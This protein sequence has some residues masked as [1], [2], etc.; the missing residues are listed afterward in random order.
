MPGPSIEESVQNSD[1]IFI[2]KCIAGE[3]IE[4]GDINSP[5]EYKYKVVWTFEVQKQI[6]GQ[7]KSVKIQVETGIGSGDCGFPFVFGFSYLVYGKLIESNIE[8]DI[9]SRTKIAGVYPINIDDKAKVELEKLNNIL[10]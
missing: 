6:K 9:C 8:T 1:V 2:G 3:F 5:S 7:Y 4:E 10:K